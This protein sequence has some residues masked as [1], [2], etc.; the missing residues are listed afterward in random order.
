M[1]MF[2]LAS[3]R[4]LDNVKEKAFFH[5][6]MTIYWQ[7]TLSCLHYKRLIAQCLSLLLGELVCI[8]LLFHVGS[9]GGYDRILGAKRRVSGRAED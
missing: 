9:P 4:S 5:M 7:I 2:A 6:A 3:W 1:Y 8:R